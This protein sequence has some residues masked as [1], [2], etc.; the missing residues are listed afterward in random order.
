MEVVGDETRGSLANV[1]QLII[2]SKW[3]RKTIAN[4]VILLAQKIDELKESMDRQK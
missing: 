1:V 4:D 2:D 3:S